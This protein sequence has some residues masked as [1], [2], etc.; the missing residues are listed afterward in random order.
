VTYGLVLLTGRGRFLK[1]LCTGYYEVPY[2]SS[3][4]YI[5]SGWVRRSRFLFL[6]VLLAICMVSVT[7]LCRYNKTGALRGKRRTIR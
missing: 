7:K 3:P 5:G 6:A 1:C 2:F 4:E